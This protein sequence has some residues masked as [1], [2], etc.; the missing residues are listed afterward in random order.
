[1]G[2]AD[3]EAILTWD[4]SYSQDPES[5]GLTNPWVKLTDLQDQ[6]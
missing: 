3:V 1:M 4:E 6:F 5:L 2:I